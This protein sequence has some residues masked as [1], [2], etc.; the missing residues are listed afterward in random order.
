MWRKIAIP[1]TNED[2]LLA[3]K[4]EK[5]IEYDNFRLKK[6]VFHHW[7]SYVKGRKER[8]KGKSLH[9]NNWFF[10]FMYPKFQQT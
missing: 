1:P 4:M 3:E 7:Y 8:L 10:V 6:C 9:S 2:D 5:S